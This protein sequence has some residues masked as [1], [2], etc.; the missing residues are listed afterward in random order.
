VIEKIS[1]VVS[2]P[3]R[4]RSHFLFIQKLN[5]VVEIVSHVTGNAIDHFVRQWEIV[6]GTKF[7]FTFFDT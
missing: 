4:L 5:K 1:C 7:G 3:K 6:I 2:A